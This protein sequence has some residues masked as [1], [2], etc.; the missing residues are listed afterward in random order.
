[1]SDK[2]FDTQLARE[3]ALIDSFLNESY[4]D[5]LDELDAE[6]GYYFDE[7]NYDDDYMIGCYPEDDIDYQE[8]YDGGDHSME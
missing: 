1:M 4:A 5:P 3:D 2:D 7:N 6:D 8:L